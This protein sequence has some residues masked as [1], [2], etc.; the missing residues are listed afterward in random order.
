MRTWYFCGCLLG[1]LALLSVSLSLS[2]AQRSEPEFKVWV[3]N[4]MIRV[5]PDTPPAQNNTIEIAAARNETEPF[6]VIISASIRKLDD[7]TATI[8]DLEDGQGNRIDHSQMTLYRQQYIY[9]RDPSPYSVEPPGWWPDALVPFLN[10]ADG[11]PVSPMQ[12]TREEMGGRIIRK[13]SGARFTASPFDVWPGKNQPLWIDVSI[14]KD[15]VPGYYTGKFTVKN[16]N[17][18]EV[19]LPV[20]LTVWNFTLPDGP[21]LATHFGSLDQI[22]AKHKVTP[23][24][25]DF[26]AIHDR[27]AK[28]MADHH[29]DPPIPDSLHPPVK[30]DGSIEW[31]KTHEGLRHYMATYNIRSVQ[32][33]TCPFADPLKTNRKYA[34]R[35]LQ[36]YY[37][38]LKAQG[39]EKGAYYYPVDEPN[40]KEAYEQVRAQAQLV[41]EANP[42]IKLLCTEQPYTQDPTWGDLRGS[43]DIWCPLFAFFEEES[44]KAARQR[45]N[46]I[47][48]YTALCQKSPPYHPQFSKVSGLSTFFWQIDFPLLNY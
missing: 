45:G 4:P 44:A 21:P 48:T 30:P 2:T 27:Y 47:W 39:W 11:R 23:G 3:E 33:P 10:P 13:L 28:A 1:L 22:A 34:I 15:A 42:E 32:I 43:V 6:Q 31:K 40:S 37:E 14:P 20:R 29:L 26:A 17:H 9:V 12:V 35:Y 8:S 41:H 16:S 38:Y 19:H 46:E 24:S 18:E 36:S 7:V 5:Q 25:S